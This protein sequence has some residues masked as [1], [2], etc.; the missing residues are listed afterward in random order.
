M[1]IRKQELTLLADRLGQSSHSQLEAQLE[2]TLKSL[3]DETKAVEDAKAA[4]V[5]AVQRSVRFVKGVFFLLDVVGVVGLCREGGW[6]GREL[7]RL[8]V[9]LLCLSSTVAS[10][11]QYACPWRFGLYLRSSRFEG[12]TPRPPGSRPSR[13]GTSVVL[14]LGRLI[15]PARQA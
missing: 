6:G 12:R 10:L 2:E 4:G 11:E 3:E 1:E 14:Y 13:F 5:A 15:Y 9:R 7:Q 8:C